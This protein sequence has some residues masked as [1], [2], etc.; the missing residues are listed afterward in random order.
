M[1]KEFAFN[2][3]DKV[4]LMHNNAAV[5]GAIAKMFFVRSVSCV[6]YES[7]SENEKYYVSVDGKVIDYFDL[8]YLFKS[9]EDL[10]N[11]L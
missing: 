11:S 2:V 10:I 7:V 4:W 3:G 5:C 8:K 9:K 6:D 1:E